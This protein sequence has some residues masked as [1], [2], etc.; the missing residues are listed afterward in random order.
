MEI[1]VYFYFE[2]L[3]FI[4]TDFQDD[5]GQHII[6][7]KEFLASLEDTVD[8]TGSGRSNKVKDQTY[9][10]TNEIIFKQ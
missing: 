9:R 10:M 5:I 4:W 2:I 6:V 8:G 3:S 7:L 1:Y